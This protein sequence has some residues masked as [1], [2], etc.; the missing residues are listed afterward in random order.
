MGLNIWQKI[1]IRKKDTCE[2]SRNKLH[3]L[4][5]I[6]D[7]IP[8]FDA[9]F[10]NKFYAWALSFNLGQHLL[11]IFKSLSKNFRHTRVFMCNDCRL[12]CKF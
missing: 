11:N 10:D 6:K 3:F 12:V 2:T 9:L 7:Q 1:Y 8:V 4:K 5:Q